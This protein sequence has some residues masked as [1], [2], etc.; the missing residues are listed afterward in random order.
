MTEAMTADLEGRL[1]LPSKALPWIKKNYIYTLFGQ[2]KK[3]ISKLGVMTAKLIA[4][5]KQLLFAGHI[6]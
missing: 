5:P 6:E 3:A 2:P 1:S 4:D